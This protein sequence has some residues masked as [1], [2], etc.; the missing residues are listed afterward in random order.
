MGTRRL[1]LC[2]I[3]A[4]LAI[5][6]SAAQH[7]P[8]KDCFPCHPTLKIGGTFFADSSAKLTVAGV[9]VVLVDSSGAQVVLEMT[10]KHGN[11]V[12]PLAPDGK[13]LVN[14]GS[15]TSRSW[16]ILPA[17]KSCNTC[18]LAGGSTPA[19][20]SYRLP[21]LHT[22]LP[23]DNDCMHC[24]HFPA[25]KSFSLLSTGG[26]LSQPAAP[27]YVPGSQV[28][29]AGQIYPFVS[30]SIVTVRPDI[31]AA[32]YFSVFD[33]ILA[34]AKDRGI[35]VEYAYD[36]DRK[37]HFITA[38]NDVHGKYWYHFSYD[39]GS[40]NAQEVQF[41][42]ANRW[43]ELLWRPG[44]WLKVVQGEDVDSLKAEFLEEINR[45]KAGGH[46]VP[47]V[48]ITINASPYR[49]N[50]AG[51]GRIAV[52]RSFQNVVVIA[53]GY[54]STGTSTPYSKPFQPGVVTAMDV[55]L[56]LQDEGQLDLVTGMF[57]SYFSGHYIDSYYVVALG[58]PGIGISHA[59]GRQGFT[60]T[61]ENGTPGRLPN[62]AD[63]KQH[64]TSD[65]LV[66]HAPDFASWQWTELGNP[67]YEST[68]PTLTS[69]LEES[70]EEDEQ[71]RSRGFNLHAPYPNPFN[72]TVGISFNVFEASHVTLEVYNVAGQYISRLY[73][74][75]P[76]SLGVHRLQW[77]PL[78]IS[79]GVYYLLLKFGSSVQVRRINYIR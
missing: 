50:P 79:S 22:R 57:Y 48:Q 42:R 13:Y 19:P 37:T 29:I 66:I 27:P 58:F 53:H 2:A 47:R 7:N 3:V 4:P 38:I 24:H 71:A 72:G 34:V 20:G 10:D 60:C 54:R 73:D 59:S 18:H 23:A 41:R 21:A 76:P 32:G 5:G 64:V 15:T 74:G 77:R 62:Q 70:I 55:L 26:V 45:E 28:E 12:S 17:Q 67:Y 16:H 8:G 44:V 63:R 43:D 75:I 33:V 30:D 40:G 51:S 78:G 39:A 6:S 1:L 11:I 25:S 56:S 52:T 65:I 69:V 35:P 49:G 36:A 46:I 9:A 61:T 14:V 68:D 31:F